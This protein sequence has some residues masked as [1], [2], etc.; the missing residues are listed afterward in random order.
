MKKKKKNIIIYLSRI[1]SGYFAYTVQ[2]WRN[3]LRNN[4]H[5]IHSYIH[6]KV[7]RDD[8]NYNLS[9]LCMVDH[10]SNNNSLFVFVWK[11]KNQKMF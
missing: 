5:K 7:Y 2:H 6:H 9:H 10:D 3:Q 4:F 8:Y 1:D 11:F